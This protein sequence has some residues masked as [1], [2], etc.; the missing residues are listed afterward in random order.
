ME[1]YITYLQLFGYPLLGYYFLRVLCRWSAR[2][3][4]A[5]Q[6]REE[7]KKVYAHAKIMR[8]RA[9]AKLK[10]KEAEVA[11]LEAGQTKSVGLRRKCNNCGATKNLLKICEYC[12]T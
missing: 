2:Q 6:E 9:L 7:A 5:G 3:R 12:G 10:V 11:E 1:D 8:D 4:Q